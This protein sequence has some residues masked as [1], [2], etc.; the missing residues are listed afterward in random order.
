MHI[1]SLFF[2]AAYEAK[3]RQEAMLIRQAKMD[4]IQKREK[5]AAAAARE[6]LEVA[7]KEREARIDLEQ[8]RRKNQEVVDAALKKIY[9][10]RQARA[11]KV[12]P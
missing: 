7:R 2:L 10:E 9:L 12:C 3:L 4:E 6:R 8:Q 5:E 1:F 11:E